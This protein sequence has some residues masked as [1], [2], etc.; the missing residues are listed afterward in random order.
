MVELTVNGRR[1]RLAVEPQATLLEVLREQ[2]GLTGTKE[3][4]D[5]GECGACTVLLEGRPVLSC[6]LLAVE[7]QGKS[8]L[9][10]EG[11]ARE[12]QLDPVQE[13]FI[14][15]GAIQC[16]F[17]TPGMLLS[18]RALLDRRPNPSVAEIKEALAGNLCRCT[19]Y[20]SIIR[21]VQRAARASQ[22]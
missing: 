9:T 10:V 19:G 22:T 16:G 8:V 14:A 20:G 15:E 3:G 11:L 6:L 13:A 7:A 5:G 4:C 2:L 17:C 12:G 1:H 21:A 18:A